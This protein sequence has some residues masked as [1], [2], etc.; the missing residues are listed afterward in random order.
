LLKDQIFQLKIQSMK[1][2]IGSILA[3]LIIYT[4]FA[5]VS[6]N[7]SLWSTWEDASLPSSG[8]LV[9]ND[10]WGYADANGREYAI[11]GSLDEVHFIEVTNPASPRKLLRSY[12][13]RL[14]Y[15]AISK[16]TGSMPTE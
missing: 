12:R 14:L 16:P 1:K 5:Q 13:V 3:F 2:L 4:A 11:L 9:Y 10:L 7:M 6:E 15:G 8:G